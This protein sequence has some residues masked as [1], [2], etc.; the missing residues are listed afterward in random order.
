M[1]FPP[2]QHAEPSN[3]LTTKDKEK[4]NNIDKD[5]DMYNGGQG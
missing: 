4:D 5:Q 2:P 3:V 1:S